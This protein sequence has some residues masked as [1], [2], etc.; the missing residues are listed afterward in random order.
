MIVRG[1]D[2][3]KYTTTSTR[4]E[5]SEILVL[6]SQNLEGSLTKEKISSEGFVT[7]RHDLATLEKMHRL[8]GHVVAKNEENKVVGYCLVLLREQQHDIPLLQPLVDR[9]YE[10]SYQIVPLSE[11]RYLIMGQVCIDKAYRRRGIFA[12]MYTFM[13]T[14]L[15][16]H[17][18]MVITS[19]SLRN[20]RSIKAHESVGFK[21]IDTFRDSIDDWVI[22]LW[23][24]RS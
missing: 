18:D 14:H 21:I 6:Q 2:F 8:H 19:I 15:K 1:K 7:V 13:K 10:L 22:V 3:I 5:L 11:H 9:I 12:G 23:D 4:K 24:W 16:E 20:K 17:F